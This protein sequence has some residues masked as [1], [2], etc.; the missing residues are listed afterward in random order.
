MKLTFQKKEGPVIRRKYVISITIIVSIICTVMVCFY[1]FT[2]DKI[3]N[4]YIDKS[5]EAIYSI[6]KDFLKDTVNNLISE[7]EM[8]REA[9]SSYMERF[10][11]RTLGIIDLKAD[12]ADREFSDFFVRFFNDNPYYD[13]VTVIQ[14]D[15]LENRAVYDPQ[16]LAGPTWADTLD[17]NISDMSA[18]RVFTHGNSSFFFG[19]TKAH[20]DNLVKAEIA[21]IIKGT[22]FD[23]DSYIWVDEILNY[24]GGKDY[25]VR[26]IHP[27]LPKMEGTRLSTDMAD[28]R[29]DFPYLTQLQGINKDGELFYNYYFKKIKGNEIAPKLTYSKLYKDYDWVISM[30]IYLDDLQ[31]YIDQTDGESRALVS[32]LTALLVL[33]LVVILIISLWSVSLIE[34][35]YYRRLKRLMES[36]MKLDP[37]TKSDSRRSG[38]KDLTDAFREFKQSGANPGIVMCDVDNFKGINDKYGHSSGDQVLIEFV[39]EM[40]SLLRSS[41][42]IIRWG[43]DEFI[44]ILYGL[45]QKN[46]LLLGNKFISAAASMRI[47]VQDEEI[48]ITISIGFSFFRETD[49][50]FTQALERADEALY[51]SKE[52]GRNQAN[53]IL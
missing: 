7:I 32:R 12:L 46:A 51:K 43:G 39:K 18:Y 44:V 36:E 16:N 42:K 45:K 20:V 14:W 35:I 11:A 52:E 33:L 37:L 13:F 28:I 30:G 19:V 9:K 38:T 4:I 53:I 17:A 41:D 25:A 1:L 6:K 34:K 21:D 26:R 24:E 49:T 40:K 50:D 31:P 5:R 29:G 10:A 15:D 2:I 3:S 47:P 23:G 22:R 8:K 27:I 48:G